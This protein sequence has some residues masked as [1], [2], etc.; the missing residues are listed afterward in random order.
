VGAR[1]RLLDNV[2]LFAEFKHQNTFS[3][4]DVEGATDQQ[5]PR[6]RALRVLIQG[7]TS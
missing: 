7:R 5:F 3:P 4:V 2:S 6:G 1:A